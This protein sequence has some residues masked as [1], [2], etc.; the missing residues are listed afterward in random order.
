MSL[1]RAVVFLW[2]ASLRNRVRQQFARLRQPRYLVGAVVGLA[3]LYGMFFRRFAFSNPRGPAEEAPIFIGFSLGMV[4]VATVVSAWL[5]GADRPA[6]TFSEAEIQHFLPAPISR[7]TLL[8]YKLVRGYLGGLLGVL[9]GAFFMQRAVGNA[10]VLFM[11]GSALSFAV[12]YLHITAASFVRT[13]MAGWGGWGKAL[14]LGAV[15]AV[16][17]GAAW[18]VFEAVHR[19]PF[20]EEVRDPKDLLGWLNGLGGEPWLWALSWPVLALVRLPLAPDAETFLWRLPVP[21]VLLGLHYAWV[22]SARVPFEESAVLRGEARARERAASRL[23]GAGQGARI[24]ARGARFLQLGAVGRPEVALVWKNLLAGW[25][26]GGSYSLIGLI[27]L[28]AA[29]QAVLTFVSPERAATLALT[30]G[31]A[32]GMFSLVLCVVGPSMFRNDLRMDLRKLDLLRAMPLTGRQVVAAELAAPAL[33]LAVMEVLLITLAVV[34]GQRLPMAH[35]VGPGAWVAG[36]LAAAFVLPAVALVNL[37]VQ[38]AGVVLFPAWLPADQERS[39]GIEAMGQRLLTFVGTLL[40]LVLGLLP[41]AFV[42]AVVGFSLYWAGDLSEWALPF[43]GLAA[44]AVLLAEVAVGVSLLGRAFESLD[45]S[46]E[47]PG[48][49]G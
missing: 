25:R 31:P 12:V 10:P 49:S 35:E 22:M 27:L 20:P 1:A 19:M 21:L 41:A 26:L 5:F 46:A 38:N 43:A 36:G 8:H 47:G 3:Y 33:T 40:V 14:R 29:I 13:R 32:S 30:L 17:G 2:G 23:G 11:L 45:V 24:R 7:R 48:L 4:L 6:V 16:L 18:V 28:A 9:F 34:L 37:V 39:R 42:A 44:A 15:L